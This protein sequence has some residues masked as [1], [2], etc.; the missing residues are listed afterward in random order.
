MECAY[1]DRVRLLIAEDEPRMAVLL[2]RGFQE[3][4]YAVDVTGNGVEAEW[5]AR[6]IDY[7]AMVLDVMLPGL[8]GFE[9]CKRLRSQ[10]C[11]TPV[12]MVTARDAVGDRIHGLD[13]GADDYLVKPFSFGELSARVRSLTRRTRDDHAPSAIVVGDLKLDPRRRR[14]WR[15]TT[16]IVLSP[17]EFTILEVL[18]RHAGEVVT[19][20]R[21][22][23]TAWDFNADHTSNV[24]DQYLAYL[25]KKIDKPFGR[26]DIETVRGVGYRLREPA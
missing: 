24:I 17:R 20:T 16:E 13:C 3:D 10:G 21:L 15:G 22:L 18:M 11:W 4:G 14:V 12:I 5:L 6:E 2:R 19:R 8:D 26:T 1:S 25:R 7:D 23:E 9:L